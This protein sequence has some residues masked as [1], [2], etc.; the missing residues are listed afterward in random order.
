MSK[1]EA[2]LIIAEGLPTKNDLSYSECLAYAEGIYDRIAPLMVREFPEEEWKSIFNMILRGTNVGRGAEALETAL[3]QGKCLWEG[4]EHMNAEAA[5]QHEKN[6]GASR[7]LARAEAKV[8]DN[9]LE[10]ES[11]RERRSLKPVIMTG[12][13]FV[14]SEH[15]KVLGRTIYFVDSRIRTRRKAVSDDSWDGRR[16]LF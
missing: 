12:T 6:R 4:G 15:S 13:N 9:I 8:G 14:Y 7:G 3:K 10:Q 11:Y 5:R 1:Q 2:I 16:I